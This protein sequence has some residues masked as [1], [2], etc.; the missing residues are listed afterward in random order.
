MR[1][2]TNENLSAERRHLRMAFEAEIV[3]ALDEHLVSDGAVRV[4]TDGAPFAQRF[5]VEDPRARLLTV[6]FRAAFVQA[7][8]A[9]RWPNTK[10]GAMRSLHH[11]RAV[12]IVALDTIHATFQDGM[13]L[14]KLELRVNVKMTC[15]ARLRVAAGIDDQLSAASGLDVQTSRPVTGFTAGRVVVGSPIDVQTG[16]RAG[17]EGAR[18][19]GMAFDTGFVP[20]ERCAFNLWGNHD[21]AGHG[22]AGR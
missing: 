9:G 18:V 15:E 4:M 3:V 12:R 1:H 11:V 5:M 20:D 10:G 13:M 19:I 2:L 17:R 22:G 6:T 14:G 8:H 7:R 16:V 21:T